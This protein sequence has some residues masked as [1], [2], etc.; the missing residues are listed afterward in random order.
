ML[1]RKSCIKNVRRHASRKHLDGVLPFTRDP[2]P[3]AKVVRVE[4]VSH[5]SDSVM[6]RAA[7]LGGWPICCRR[8]SFS[9]A[10]KAG[11]FPILSCNDEQSL[12]TDASLKVSV[13]SMTDASQSSCI[14]KTKPML[15]R[16]RFQGGSGERNSI[17]RPKATASIGLTVVSMWSI[18]KA[19]VLSYLPAKGP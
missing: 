13:W 15:Q 8:W 16:E 3:A 19:S 17:K 14:P 18:I 12:F 7:N 1:G 2:R 11:S 5:L 9:A 6:S 10:D 4:G